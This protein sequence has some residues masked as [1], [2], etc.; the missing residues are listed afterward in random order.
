MNT[1]TKI[2]LCC[3]HIKSNNSSSNIMNTIS[4][5][6]STGRIIFFHFFLFNLYYTLHSSQ[7][8]QNVS[9]SS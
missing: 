3:T 4:F 5:L 8:C 6:Y 9:S 1:Q 2:S 7:N